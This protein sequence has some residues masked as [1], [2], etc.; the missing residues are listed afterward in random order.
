MVKR[1]RGHASPRQSMNKW[2]VLVDRGRFVTDYVHGQGKNRMNGVR[3]VPWQVGINR[4]LIESFE[5]Q[6][7]LTS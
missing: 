1:P 7:R 6:R 2:K 5:A 3:P 4:L